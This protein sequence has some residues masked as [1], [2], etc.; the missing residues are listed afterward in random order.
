MYI[1]IVGECV[2]L[3]NDE[4]DGCMYVRTKRSA[5]LIMIATFRDAS[6]FVVLLYFFTIIMISMVVSV[7]F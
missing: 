1:M 5:E 4:I 6:D 7:S 3:E 2:R